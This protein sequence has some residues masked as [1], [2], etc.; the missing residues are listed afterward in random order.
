MIRFFVIADKKAGIFTNH[1]WQSC[2]VVYRN[3]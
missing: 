3:F 1:I 2:S